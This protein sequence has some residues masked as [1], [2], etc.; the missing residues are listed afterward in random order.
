MVLQKTWVVYTAIFMIS[1][2]VFHLMRNLLLILRH[3]GKGGFHLKKVMLSLLILLARCSQT[4][5]IPP[6]T[7]V[8]S[9]IDWA[10]VVMWN[11]SHYDHNY[12]VNELNQ[13]WEIGEELGE[14]TYMM[15]DHAGAN[16]IMKNGHATLFDA[17]YEIVCNGGL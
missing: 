8:H 12:R 17:R 14:V 11:D 7:L 1:S 15:N 5:P 9:T 2:H 4:N 3:I 13:T 6:Q 16:H 10:D